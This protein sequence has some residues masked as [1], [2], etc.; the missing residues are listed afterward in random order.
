[1]LRVRCAGC[2][3]RDLPGASA[4]APELRGGA[5]LDSNPFKSIRNLRKLFELK[6][7]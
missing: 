7:S 5:A 1:M 2:G 6:S 4:A 3:L